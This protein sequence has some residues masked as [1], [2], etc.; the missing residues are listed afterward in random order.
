MREDY[1]NYLAEIGHLRTITD[2][3]EYRVQRSPEKNALLSKE[4]G[5]WKAVTWKEYSERV[6][7]FG[8]AL[9]ASGLKTGD[10]AA[11]IGANYPEW[12]IADMGTMTAG[13]V[14]VPVYAT[15]SAD[16]IIYILN[17]SEAK[18]FVMDDMQYFKRIESQLAEAKT[19]KRIVLTKGQAPQDNDLIVDLDS[20]LR[21]GDKIDDGELKKMRDQV[22]PDTLGSMVYTSG[23]TGPPKAVMLTHQ[24]SVA[25][26]K[27]IYLIG[28]AGGIEE[29]QENSFSYLPLS[30]VAERTVN[31]YTTLLGGMPIYFME[32]YDKFQEYILEV[33]PGAWAGVPR[34]WE[35]IHEGV[36]A[37]RQEK[38]PAVQKIIAWALAVGHDYNMR[39]YEKKPFPV[40]LK[41][42]Y[43]VAH[44][45]VIKKILASIGMDRAKIAITGGGKTS[46]EITRF[47][48][49]LGVFFGEVYG[50]TEG[51][52][53]TSMASLDELK[54]GTQGKPFP[55]V[56][57]KIAEDGEILVKGPN[58]SPGYYKDPE[59][60]AQTFKDGWLYSGDLGE[61][62]ED[63]YLK[64]TG[65]KK[66]IIITS[67]G[68]NITPAKTEAELCALPLIEHAM[69]VG[70]GKKYLTALLTLVAEEAEKLAK[71]EGV[72]IND[73]NDYLEVDSIVNAVDEHVQA[74]NNNLSRVEQIKKYR[75]LPVSFTVEGGELSNI[76]KLK[77]HVVTERYGK[78]IENLYK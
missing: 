71:K 56:E 28:K 32:S 63:G 65:R 33:R 47:F 43:A 13:C 22:T 19:L 42:K 25:A 67:G 57:V 48:H 27:N 34:V 60:T 16:Q 72:Q 15:N 44:S 36:M 35:K 31:L 53:T 78:K 61:L 11:L 59:L 8:K 10:M 62:D 54:L 41:M 46:E 64:I 14:S 7:R 38:S 20:F 55:L 50:Q 51:H 21:T 52:G 29:Y 1:K 37:Y 75:I 39:G 6:K 74:V 40:A 45:L 12:F 68:K 66:D 73:R 26:G 58:V 9:I 2:L 5:Q 30:H 49:S 77:R 69:V 18:V 4:T 17:H 23:T 3:F 24:N 70:D 76:M